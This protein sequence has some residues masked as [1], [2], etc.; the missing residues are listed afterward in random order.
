MTLC[1]TSNNDIITLPLFSKWLPAWENTEVYT[2]KWDFTHCGKNEQGPSAM[3][4]WQSP[5]YRRRQELQQRKQRPDQTWK[6]NWEAN[7]FVLLKFCLTDHSVTR[8][9]APQNLYWMWNQSNIPPNRTLLYFFSIGIP[10]ASLNQ[11]TTLCRDWYT[12][13]CPTRKKR[14]KYNITQGEYKHE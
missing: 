4:V 3:L 14:R 13:S 2:A 9:R 6:A 11:S 12:T 8:R 7:F 1:L 5:C 10:T